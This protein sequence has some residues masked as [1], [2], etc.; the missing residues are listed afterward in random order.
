MIA[1]FSY[2]CI[3][4]VASSISIEFISTHLIITLSR[5]DVPTV[6][7]LSLIGT[8]LYKVAHQ[9]VRLN[10]RLTALEKGGL[11]CI[12]SRNK[13][14]DTF[15]HSTAHEYNINLLVTVAQR[16][17]QAILDTQLTIRRSSQRVFVEVFCWRARDSV[18]NKSCAKMQNRMFVLH[19]QIS[20]ALY[21]VTYFVM[22]NIVH[23][24][25]SHF[26][27]RRCSFLL[28]RYIGFEIFRM[29]IIFNRDTV[30]YIF[31]TLLK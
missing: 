3:V 25:C 30:S 29:L 26:L 11:S 16:S 23:A 1:L 9:S 24:K 10:L 20:L 22:F 2:Y 4:C 7:I 31:K 5:A 12:Q 15:L 18:S 14:R 13:D 17:S 6:H 19:A 21:Y 8:G 27:F 28:D